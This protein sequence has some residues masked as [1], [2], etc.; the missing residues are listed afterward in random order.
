MVNFF[1]LNLIFICECYLITKIKS[2]LHKRECDR[3]G[4][5]VIDLTLVDNC[6]Y[7]YIDG[8][9]SKTYII[10]LVSQKLWTGP[11]ILVLFISCSN[12]FNLQNEY[13]RRRKNK[14]QKIQPFK[15]VLSLLRSSI[16]IYKAINKHISFLACGPEPV[17]GGQRGNL[18]FPQKKH[19]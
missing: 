18:S 7:I 10:I 3:G 11:L 4:N 8:R 15:Y 9:T 17:N 16:R 12:D 14:K 1:C 19:I 5:M 6:W 13:P 2:R